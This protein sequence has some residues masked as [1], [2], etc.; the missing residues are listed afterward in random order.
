VVCVYS[1]RLCALTMW[2][3][4]YYRED[5]LPLHRIFTPL[6]RVSSGSCLYRLSVLEIDFGMLTVYVLF[7][8]GTGANQPVYRPPS[9]VLYL[10]VVVTPQMS[11]LDYDDGPTQT[12]QRSIACWP[13]LAGLVT[14]YNKTS[15]PSRAPICTCWI[16]K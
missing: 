5:L 4:L 13:R 16:A 9:L 14:V 12:L 6:A 1:D 15:R 11:F 8:S 3:G 7:L 10:P 2:Q